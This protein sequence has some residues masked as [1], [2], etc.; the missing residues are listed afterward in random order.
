MNGEPWLPAWDA[1]LYAENTAHHRAYDQS[2][3]DSTPLRPDH[4]LVDLGC[5]T[6]DFTRMLADRLP[7][8]EVMGIDPQPAFI[9]DARRRAGPNQRFGVGT[10]QRLVDALGGESFDGILSRAALHWAP[11]ADQALIARQVFRS[12]EPGGFFR[13]DMGGAGNIP[14]TVALLDSVSMALGGPTAPWCF[15]DPAWYLEILEATGFEIEAGHV[16]SVAQRR[17]FTEESVWGWLES[18]VFAAYETEMESSSV[19]PFRRHTRDRLT[20]LRRHDG[21]FDQTF[22]RLDV[23][24]FVPAHRG[25]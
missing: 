6:G 24:A 18:Q 16:R 22:V 21:T 20:E 11:G 12:I 2:F 8:G 4:R 5:G 13:L 3:L 14:R 25:R 10:G 7:G 23:L 17:P 1:E 19:E 15:P 9:D